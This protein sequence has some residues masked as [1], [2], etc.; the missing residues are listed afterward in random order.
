MTSLDVGGHPSSLEPQ[1]LVNLRFSRHHIRTEGY[2]WASH[3]MPVLY[4]Y[5][6]TDHTD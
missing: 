4:K 2:V 5:K 3:P 6:N 1:L